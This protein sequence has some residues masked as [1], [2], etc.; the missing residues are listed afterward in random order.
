[1]TLASFYS[2]TKRYLQCDHTEKPAE[3][4]TVR[5]SV[6]QEEQEGQQPLT[7]QRAANFRLLDNQ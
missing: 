1:M 2:P 3:R 4:P 6:N 5:I 7:G